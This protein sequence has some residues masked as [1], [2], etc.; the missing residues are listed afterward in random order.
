M[1]KKRKAK[2]S[3][4]TSSTPHQFRPFWKP[5]STQIAH[6]L[7]S[8]ISPFR[9]ST[10]AKSNSWFSIETTKNLLLPASVEPVPIPES[11]FE[12]PEEKI[13]VK[14]G[15]RQK[16]GP[17]N[18]V[19]KTSLIRL[20]PHDEDKATIRMWF[21]HYRKTYN[22]CL[23]AVKGGHFK[24]SDEYGLR[25]RF[26]SND[27]PLP[28]KLKYL[29][30]TP[31]HIRAGAVAELCGNYGKEFAKKK[32][33]PSHMFDVK[34]KS[35][36]TKETSI[37]IP[38]GGFVQG[39]LK[40]ERIFYSTKIKHAIKTSPD[41]PPT[42]KNADARMTVNSLG[43][44]FLCVATDFPL[45]P[46]N[47]NQAQSNVISL[48]PGIRTFMTGFCPNNSE[49]QFIEY[50][51]GDIGKIMRLCTHLDKL[52]GDTTRVKNNKKRYRM[53]KAADRLR[54]R[55]QRL[56]RD[57]HHRIV[58]HLVTNHDVIIIPEFKVSNMA[59]RATRKIGKES[60]RKMINWGHYEFRQRL[61]I[62]A[63]EHQKRVLVVTEEYTSKT[64]CR[65]GTI[66]QQLGGN[67]TFSCPNPECRLVIDRDFNG[68]I[69]ILTKRLTEVHSVTA[70]SG[71]A[72]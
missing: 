6:P 54:L 4:S 26:V 16:L 12:K 69:N 44:F 38:K 61:L 67:K 21:S 50:G 56:R 17:E 39:K 62:K 58:H 65:C 33:D 23:A 60:V 55:I 48:D 40:T 49:Y 36:R 25:K 59:N 7:L 30:D 52:I 32:K 19:K 24:P 11:F 3:P 28:D 37:Y 2:D 10:P 64:C 72:P 29:L 70:P 8:K 14:C 47:V 9:H 13:R 51:K 41:L 27:P 71:F 22:L 1:A 35:C 63:K 15:K 66:H 42:F 57:C 53:R 34:F 5:V 20:F 31:N 46:D 68:A 45:K 43:H 18:T